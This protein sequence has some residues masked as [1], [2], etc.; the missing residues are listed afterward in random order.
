MYKNAL[1]QF[2]DRS[3]YMNAYIFHVYVHFIIR[4]V[5]EAKNFW[6]ARAGIV[7]LFMEYVLRRFPY[8]RNTEMK[9]RVFGAEHKSAFEAHKPRTCTRRQRSFPT[10]GKWEKY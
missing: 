7:A 5:V 10:V 3:V 1:C 2:F 9:T 8:R 6:V 4:R